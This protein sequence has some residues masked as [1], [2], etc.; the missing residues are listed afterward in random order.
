[1]ITVQHMK[2]KEVAVRTV[3]IYYIIF[4]IKSII[5][6]T[7]IFAYFYLFIFFFAKSCLNFCLVDFVFY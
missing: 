5:N 1:M 6:G 3:Y 7:F 4:E 2:P